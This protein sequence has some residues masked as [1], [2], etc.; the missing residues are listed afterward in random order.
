MTECR[1]LVGYVLVEKT[2][3]VQICQQKEMFSCSNSLS[4][5]TRTWDIF[6]K[7]TRNCIECVLGVEKGMASE[8]SLLVL[9]ALEA[10]SFM[11]T[12]LMARK[13]VK[14]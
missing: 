6:K 2:Q 13:A 4:I 10:M 3:L 11:G 9:N 14:H 12:E 7:Q 8:W 5:F 1:L